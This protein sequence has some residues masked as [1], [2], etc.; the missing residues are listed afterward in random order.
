MEGEVWVL[1][2]SDTVAEPMEVEVTLVMDDVRMPIAKLTTDA[3]EA[4]K[5]G[6]FGTFRLAITSG[7]PERFSLELTC[8][9][10]PTVDSQYALVH[11]ADLAIG[12]D[13]A[14]VSVGG[15]DDFSDFLKFLYDFS[16]FLND[17]SIFDKIRSKVRL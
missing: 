16:K 10:D 11:R 1:N 4:R 12:T 17:F 3:V 2:D 14:S 15:N 7:I 8:K 13:G 6:K 9:A 5:N